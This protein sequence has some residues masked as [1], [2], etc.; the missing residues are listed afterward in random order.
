MCEL[1]ISFD[2][3]AIDDTEYAVLGVHPVPISHTTFSEPLVITTSGAPHI[4]NRDDQTLP[5]LILRR[6][7]IFLPTSLDTVKLNGEEFITM[8]ILT[9]ESWRE[10]A[11]ARLHLKHHNPTDIHIN[12]CVGLAL[13]VVLSFVSILVAL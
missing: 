5:R 11:I 6:A 7:N 8:A 12:Q 2:K 10:A 3:K 4:S 13:G 9:L 1:Q